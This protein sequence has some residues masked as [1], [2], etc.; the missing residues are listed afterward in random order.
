[1]SHTTAWRKDRAALREFT[2]TTHDAIIASLPT[3]D[4]AAALQ[5]RKRFMEAFDAE[6]AAGE[7]LARVLS[8]AT[9]ATTLPDTTPSVLLAWLKRHELRELPAITIY[10]QVWEEGRPLCGATLR[11]PSALVWSVDESSVT[12]DMG[13][14]GVAQAGGGGL[15]V[16]GQI[17]LDLTN[18]DD[19]LDAFVSVLGRALSAEL[20]TRVRWYAPTPNTT[21][22][23][24]PHTHI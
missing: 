12:L 7:E 19:S 18:L 5:A 1:M 20:A 21:F 11:V 9:A 15:A 22:S 23:R 10:S 3:A 14:I 24:Q 6:T 2:T 4:A 13:Q 16:L 17:D 8:A